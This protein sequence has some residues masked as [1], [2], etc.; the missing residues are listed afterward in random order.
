MMAD[1]VL[2]HLKHIQ[3]T[4]ANL[5]AGQG[6]MRQRLSATETGIAGIRRDL[7]LLAETDAHLAAHLDRQGDRLERIE[8]RLEIVG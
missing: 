8:H 3:A 7:A 4:L 5:E 1:L 2:E 6:E